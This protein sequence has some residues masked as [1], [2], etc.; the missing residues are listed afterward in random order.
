MATAWNLIGR[1]PPGPF[2]LG[3]A[4]KARIGVC[5]PAHCVA[6][7]HLEAAYTV[8]A[9]PQFCTP[10]WRSEW[11]QRRPEKGGAKSAAR[12]AACAPRFGIARVSLPPSR[13]QI[14]IRRFDDPAPRRRHSGMLEYLLRW[15]LPG[16]RGRSAPWADAW[17]NPDRGHRPA[18]PG[19]APNLHSHGAFTYYGAAR[20]TATKH[21]PAGG[22]RALSGHR[23]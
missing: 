6:G 12:S 1:T 13:M 21:P 20:R 7:F 16:P 11:E 9:A 3:D 8:C 15:Y 22:E 14:S 19:T 10:R 4:N 18:E 17:Q 2:L 5:V 23:C